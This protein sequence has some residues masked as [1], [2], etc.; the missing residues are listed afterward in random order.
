[1]TSQ[2]SK[3]WPVFHCPL[4]TWSRLEMEIWSVNEIIVHIST[5][6]SR[7]GFQIRIIDNRTDTEFSRWNFWESI[8][9]KWGLS[10]H[11]CN[12]SLPHG[13]CIIPRMFT[14]WVWLVEGKSQVWNLKGRMSE[15]NDRIGPV[16]SMPMIRGGCQQYA[17]LKQY[18]LILRYS[19]FCL[20][21]WISVSQCHTNMNINW[22]KYAK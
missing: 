12:V 16:N 14:D 1:M 4:Y 21:S 11:P 9:M 8:F 18:F 6:V 13:N 7:N 3:R 20:Y 15:E 10:K 5:W 19:I 17:N 2:L 22:K